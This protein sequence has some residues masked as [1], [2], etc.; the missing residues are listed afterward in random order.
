MTGKEWAA[1]SVESY[2]RVR[3]GIDALFPCFRKKEINVFQ[4][5]MKNNFRNKMLVVSKIDGILIVI[6]LEYDVCTP[7]F[8]AFSHHKSLVSFPCLY[9]QPNHPLCL[10]LVC[11]VPVCVRFK[12]EVVCYTSGEGTTICYC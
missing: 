12:S 8:V 5:L 11:E 9:E 6:I 1:L 2:V 4:K 10:Y 3:W 7:N